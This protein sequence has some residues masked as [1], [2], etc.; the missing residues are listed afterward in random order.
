VVEEW[1]GG[2]GWIDVRRKL[3][4]GYGLSVIRSLADLDERLGGR[5]WPVVARRVRGG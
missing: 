1:I 2:L 5:A 4:S 3:L